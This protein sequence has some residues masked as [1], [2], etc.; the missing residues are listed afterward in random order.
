LVDPSS[1][2]RLHPR[3]VVAGH[4]KPEALDD[5]AEKM[6]NATR[7][8][9]SGFRRS[10]KVV[11]N[12]RRDRWCDATQISQSRKPNHFAIFSESRGQ[13]Q[14]LS[15]QDDDREC[16]SEIFGIR[17]QHVLSRASQRSQRESRLARPGR[18][19]ASK[20]ARLAASEDTSRNDLEVSRSH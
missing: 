1:T 15:R 20:T 8:Y 14:S 16:H 5:E 19:E 3:I 17:V 11:R 6:V 4:K 10:S 2:G 9:D 18:K 13:V 12:G 7:F